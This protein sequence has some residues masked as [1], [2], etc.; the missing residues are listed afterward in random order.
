MIGQKENI[1]LLRLF[2]NL[3]HFIILSGEKGSGR[4]LM[5]KEECA[6]RGIPVM[7]IKG[8][9]ET[10][11]NLVSYSATTCANHCFLIDSSSLTREA[12][13]ALLKTCEETPPTIHIVLKIEDGEM[14][15]D[16]LFSRAFFLKMGRYSFE[17]KVEYLASIKNQYDI[18]DDEIDYLLG[19]FVN[20]GSINRLLMT[21]NRGKDLVDFVNLVIEN[22]GRAPTF[23][24]MK[25][26][27]Q[28]AIKDENDKFPLDLFF[29]LFLRFFS[30]TQVVGEDA[31]SKIFHII[32]RNKLLGLTAD[33]IVKLRNNTLSKE[34]ILTQWIMLANECFGSKS[35]VEKNEKGAP[36]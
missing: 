33:A 21:T 30:N 1:S 16:T 11:R 14:V 5:M 7:E 9:M 34:R 31:N 28:L 3:P 35:N 4:T 32:S 2:D 19:S 15:M 22:I 6:R 17:E 20:P 24:V 8:D 29:Y 18:K 26:E 36:A 12:A 10:I 23:N 25:I 27:K 13:N